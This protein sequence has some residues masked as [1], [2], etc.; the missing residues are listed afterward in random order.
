LSEYDLKCYEDD[1]TL[2]MKESLILF[3]EISNTRYFQ[4]LPIF[5][6]FNKVDLF[7]EKIKNVDLNVCFK[8]YT[9]GKDYD[10]AIQYIQ[11]IFLDKVQDEQKK[12]LL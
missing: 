10:K 2:R 4:D 8:E 12:V 3:E 5:L 7:K 6:F 11:K 1:S 9:G